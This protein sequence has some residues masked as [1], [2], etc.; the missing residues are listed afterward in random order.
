MYL[1]TVSRCTAQFDGDTRMISWK[2]TT[3]ELR[4]L[5]MQ[6]AEH[7]E[8]W[9]RVDPILTTELVVTA[10]ISLAQ[11]LVSLPH[12]LLCTTMTVQRFT[13]VDKSR[14]PLRTW[15]MASASTCQVDDTKTQLTDNEVNWQ[16]GAFIPHDATLPFS[17]HPAF[18][19]GPGV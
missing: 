13:V 19:G 1:C 3:D 9:D 14:C 4:P 7:Y 6:S 17:S 16:S 10:Q 2:A 8:S 11:L 18:K 12:L 5:R 15:F